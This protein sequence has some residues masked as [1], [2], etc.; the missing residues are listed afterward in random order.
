MKEMKEI[1]LNEKKLRKLFSV[2]VN[3]KKYDSWRNSTFY[4]KMGGLY[5]LMIGADRKREINVKIR[6]KIDL[7]L[8]ILRDVVNELK[9]KYEE[10][11]NPHSV[12]RGFYGSEFKDSWIMAF[13]RNNTDQ[14]AKEYCKT[15]K[16]EVENEVLEILKTVIK[17]IDFEIWD[18][19]FRE[20][21]RLGV[22]F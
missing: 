3:K 16:R 19:E 7:P 12:S 6:F 11:H 17:E 21:K 10:T 15:I 20:L 22:I 9:H 14:E 4:S 5:G 1:K 8:V 2:Q 18:D 13:D